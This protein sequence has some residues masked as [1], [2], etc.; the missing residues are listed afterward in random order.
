M[1]RWLIPILSIAGLAPC[2]D[3][4]AA[5][6]SPRVLE[7]RTQNVQG[8][9]YF[10]VRLERPA[11]LGLPTFDT[12]RPFSESDRRRFARLPRLLP[13]DDKTR[14]VYYRHRPTQPGLSFCGQLTGDSKAKFVLLYPLAETEPAKPLALADLVRSPGMAELTVELDFAKAAAVPLP[15][16]DAEDQHLNRKDLRGY[17]AL[18]QAAHF[19]VLETQVIDFPFYSF[20]REATGRK[21]GIVSPAW[22]KR[23]VSDAEHRLYEITT[24]ADAIAETLQLHRMLQPDGRRPAERSIDLAGVEG[25]TVPEQPWARMLAGK[26]PTIEPLAQLIPHDNYYVHFKSI[27][28]FLEFGELLDQWGTNVLRVY[29]VK[30]RDY[31][32]RERY[33]KQLCLKSTILGKTLGP[34]LVKGVAITGSDPYVREGTDVTVI[35]QA[36]NR[37]LFLTAVDGFIRDAR[38]EY[39]DRLREGKDEYHGTTIERFVTP[40]REVSLHRAV[41]GDFVI[42][43]NSP[44]GVRRVL[45][46]HRKASKC[47]ADMSDFRYLRT[48]FAPEDEAEDGFVFL[49]D[50]FLRQLTGPASR[51]KEKRRVEALTSLSMVTNAA[52]F[53]AWET[54][55][56]PANV[57]AALAGAGL[58][59]EDVA[60]PEG[61]P[62]R[63][64]ADRQQAV[65]GVY[66]TIHF[67]TPLIELPIDKI[68]PAEAADYVRFRDEY[69]RLWRTYFDPIGL[70][71]SFDAKRVRVETHILPLAG[72]EQYRSLRAIAG[73]GTF[74]FHPRTEGVVEF[75]LSVGDN[76]SF[77]LHLDQNAF[78]REMVEL[79]IRWEADP[80][81]NWRQEYDRLFWKLP[82]GVSVSELGPASNAE[83][84]VNL[85][86]Q[87]GLLKE[88]ATVHQHKGVAVHRLSI[89][90]D[91]YRDLAAVA[92]QSTT[93][94]TPFATILALLPLRE[95]PPALYIADID[96]AI[97]VSAN[98]D[99]LKKLIDQAEVRKNL[100]PLNVLNASREVNAGLF[101]SPANAGAA[102]SLFLEY[103]GHNLTLLN[104]K[105][106]QAFYRAGVLAPGAPESARKETARRFLGYLPVSPDGSLYR[107]EPRLGE[108]ANERHGSFR[109]PE[110]HSQVAD[111]SELGQ[112]LNQIKSLRAELRFGDNSLQTVL[113]IERR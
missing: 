99:F 89:V 53:C 9:T 102:A 54:G 88:K 90:E 79:L 96:K 77:G 1:T 74:R 106:W 94:S 12:N 50:A 78:L 2:F 33:E 17:W 32:L 91:R 82:F 58:R 23:Q 86:Q 51:I 113:T 3:L 100:G 26:Q 40:L 22:V 38:Q 67:A 11:N 59:P 81:V 25:I 97:H 83:A 16:I 72:T 111:G 63:W 60:V 52:W 19:A 42:Y 20:G 75:R 70:R 47:L 66:G 107:Y 62:I 71:L 41:V 65:S 7:L 55:K 8:I 34:A 24:G 10:H 76:G 49:S 21:Y 110:L 109:R 57:E 108:V 101:I 31:Q 39:G 93:D 44:A 15:K 85:V 36:A 92:N 48:L 27:R 69:V 4:P 46:A 95:V 73:Q 61:K 112:V 43:A 84:I 64:D 13:Q 103:E 45:D 80:R 105:V 56:L 14:A 5:A 18:H 6:E 35:F 87:V 37:P 30:S 68:T 104:N 29:E 98:E 28:K